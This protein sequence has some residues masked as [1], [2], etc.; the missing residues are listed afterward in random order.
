M[1]KRNQ[2]GNCRFANT[3]TKKDKKRDGRTWLILPDLICG[4][5]LNYYQSPPQFVLCCYSSCFLHN[6]TLRVI[7]RRPISDVLDCN[8]GVRLNLHIRHAFLQDEDAPGA[9][10]FVISLIFINEEEDEEEAIRRIAQMVEV[11]D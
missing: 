8:T 3:Y 7:W 4:L 6:V 5:H 1:G 11:D 2:L 10:V 9:F